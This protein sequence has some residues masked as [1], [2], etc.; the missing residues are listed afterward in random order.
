[1]IRRK[2]SLELIELSKIVKFKAMYT[3][4][5]FKRFSSPSINTKFLCRL[6]ART[7]ICDPRVSGVLCGATCISNNPVIIL[8][9]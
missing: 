8:I 3:Y 2:N 6:G 1:M 9:F 5:N 7:F 4:H